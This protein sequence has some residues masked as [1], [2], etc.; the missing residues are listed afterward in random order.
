MPAHHALD[1]GPGFC[2]C[3]GSSQLATCCAS[4][5]RKSCFS[6]SSVMLLLVALLLALV[7]VG[8]DQAYEKKS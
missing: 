1:Q 2:Y 6:A 7:P 4:S 3:N 8:S 5:N